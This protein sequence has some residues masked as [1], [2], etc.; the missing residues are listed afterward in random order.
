MKLGLITILM[1]V[2][3]NIFMTVAWYGQLKLQGMGLIK[4]WP[5]YLVIL[6][7]WGVALLEYCFMI[8]ANRM[9][10]ITNGGR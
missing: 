2:I 1:L 4:N 5:L 10:I 8:P 9:G 3:S 6:A 7:S